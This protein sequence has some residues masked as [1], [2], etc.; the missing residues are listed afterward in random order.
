MRIKNLEGATS[1]GHAGETYEAD[2]DGMFD[3]PQEVGEQL[4][5]FPHWVREH[6]Y[7][8]KA[9]AAQTAANKDPQTLSVRVAALESVLPGMQVRIQELEARIAELGKAKPAAAAQDAVSEDEAESA[10]D[11]EETDETETAEKPQRARKTAASP[12][13]K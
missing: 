13:R 8:D 10:D 9:A 4:V 7:L 12:K 11:A 3:V 1:L 5:S 2:A 6:E